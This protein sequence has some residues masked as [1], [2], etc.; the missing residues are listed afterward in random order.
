MLPSQPPSAYANSVPAGCKQ[1]ATAPALCPALQTVCLLTIALVHMK[2][3]AY[4]DMFSHLLELH[5]DVLPF[6]GWTEFA[7]R[8]LFLIAKRRMGLSIAVVSVI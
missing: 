8:S 2:S 3:V 1:V 5:K 6:T 4:G 7:S